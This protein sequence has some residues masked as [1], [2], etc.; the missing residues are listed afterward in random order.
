MGDGP[1]CPHTWRHGQPAEP[2]QTD[3]DLTTLIRDN[4]EQINLK[5]TQLVVKPFS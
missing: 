5:G 3:Q 4:A 1:R 2:A